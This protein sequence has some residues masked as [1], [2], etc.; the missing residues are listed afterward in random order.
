MSRTQQLKK[1]GHARVKNGG[2][3]ELR[4]RSYRTTFTMRT[5]PAQRSNRGHSMSSERLLTRVKEADGGVLTQANRV[6]GVDLVVERA[7]LH[8][9]RCGHHLFLHRYM[10]NQAGTRGGVTKRTRLLQKLFLATNENPQILTSLSGSETV[11][12]QVN[13]QDADLTGRHVCLIHDTATREHKNARFQH[14]KR[15]ILR[16]NPNTP[17]QYQ[18]TQRKLHVLC[19]ALTSSCEMNW[20]RRSER[21]TLNTRQNLRG[22]HC[23]PAVEFV[24]DLQF[25]VAVRL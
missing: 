20:C 9:L 12:K 4:C 3:K 10:T 23:L 5:P 18:Q 7:E 22:E 25:V 15:G 21:P 8:V 6:G 13:T 16:R 24:D 11:A 1:C 17:V 19:L 2:A 14:R